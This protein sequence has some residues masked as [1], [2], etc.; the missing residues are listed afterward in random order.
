MFSLIFLYASDAQN[1]PVRFLAAT[2]LEWKIKSPFFSVAHTSLGILFCKMMASQD[3]KKAEK[4]QCV[5]W[6][7]GK[8][9][10]HC[11]STSLTMEL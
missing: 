3:F 11:R 7:I 9:W 6:S 1:H 4:A 2:Y 10:R 8:L 5:I